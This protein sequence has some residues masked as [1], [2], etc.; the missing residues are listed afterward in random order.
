VAQWA[1][2]T[3][4]RTAAHHFASARRWDDL[5]RVLDTHV[6]TIGASGAFSA[7]EEFLRNA[8][9]AAA[10]STTE[11]IRSRIA[12]AQGDYRKG[13]DLARRAL[14]I[15]PESDVVFENMRSAAMLDG[16]Y[17]EAAS[18]VENL[19]RVA[20]SE[21]MRDVANATRTVL[22]SSLDA[23]LLLAAQMCEAL[24]DKCHRDGLG[25]FEGVSWL[26]SGLCYRAHG[27]V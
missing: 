6:E 4:W 1:E 15:A 23:D 7:A 12:V 8:P 13:T 5:R 24:A 19:S 22:A 18:I 2:S 11:V 16:R 21:L 26:N 27:N 20:K 17:G 14:A 10:S 9:E 3:D 25:H